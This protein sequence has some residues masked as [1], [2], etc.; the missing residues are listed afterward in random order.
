M[1][2]TLAVPTRVPLSSA[3]PP[4]FEKSSLSLCSAAASS[5]PQF[6]PSLLYISLS[7]LCLLAAAHFFLNCSCCQCSPSLPLI[8]QRTGYLSFFFSFDP[9]VC[10]S[11]LLPLF[12]F[13]SSSTLL[14][15]P[16]FGF[17]P[18]IIIFHNY[19]LCSLLLSWSLI[20]YLMLLSSLFSI[21]M[22]WK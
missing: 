21:N 14:H 10:T 16:R 13:S 2:K 1:T 12:S 18:F 7:V 11:C 22:V 5:P 17:F 8:C 3:A 20:F 15:V 19:L 4:Q 6:E 9:P